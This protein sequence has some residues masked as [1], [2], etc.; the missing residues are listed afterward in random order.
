MNK[1]Y[2]E[3][4]KTKFE[5]EINSVSIDFINDHDLSDSQYL[6][7]AFSEFSDSN[8]SVYYCDQR[9]YFNEHQEECEDALLEL[10]DSDSLADI[11]K[12]RGLDGLICHAGAIGEYESIYHQLNEDENSICILLV[13]NHL[14]DNFSNYEKNPIPNTAVDELLKDVECTNIDRI[15]DLLD[16][17]NDWGF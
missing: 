10:Y 5:S 15:S 4:L 11:I 9:T 3:E 17:V 6:C 8:T 14:L 16:I 13:I 12:T 1:Q 2:L 7:D